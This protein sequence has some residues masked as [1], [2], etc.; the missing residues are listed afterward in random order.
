MGEHVDPLFVL[1]CIACWVR[2]GGDQS[3]HLTACI[4]LVNP[5]PQLRYLAIIRSSGGVADHYQSSVDD[6][7]VYMV[8]QPFSPGARQHDKQHMERP[9][10]P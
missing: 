5:S 7:L 1:A 4:S 2:D 9:V 3:S 8:R 6:I 10:V